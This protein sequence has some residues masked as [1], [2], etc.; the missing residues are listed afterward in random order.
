VGVWVR[1]SLPLVQPRTAAAG[2]KVR[3][4]V[5]PFHPHPNPPPPGEG[6]AAGP[7]EATPS[8]R[9]RAGWWKAALAGTSPCTSFRGIGWLCSSLKPHRLARVPDEAQIAAFTP[10]MRLR[11]PSSTATTKA[12]RLR[13]LMSESERRLSAPTSSTSSASRLGSVSNLT[14]TN[15]RIALPRISA[16]TSFWQ[17]Q[18]SRRCGSAPGSFATTPKASG[19]TSRPVAVSGYRSQKRRNPNWVSLG[20]RRSGPWGPAARVGLREDAGGRWDGGTEAFQ[21]QLETCLPWAWELGPRSRP[22]QEPAP[23]ASNLPRQ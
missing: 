13:R 23:A 18:A 9:G 5:E 11:N 19:T 20:G 8:P 10:T 21:A 7:S 6:T 1:Q 4:A 17:T 22:K 2:A 12:R 16:E 14:E 15:M 3:G